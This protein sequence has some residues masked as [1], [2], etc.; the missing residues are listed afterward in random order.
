MEISKFE[1]YL[2]KDVFS[3]AIMDNDG[4]ASLPMFTILEVISKAST[5]EYKKFLKLCKDYQISN[6]PNYSP[7]ELEFLRTI[8]PFAGEL[9]NSIVEIPKEIVI[10]FCFKYSK[11]II[12]RIGD[13]CQKFNIDWV[14]FLDYFFM[15]KDSV[16]LDGET[17]TIPRE[18][19]INARESLD[20][21][22]K[23]V[24]FDEM[25]DY[26][27]L[28][29]ETRENSEVVDRDS[30]VTIFNHPENFEKEDKTETRTESFLQLDKIIKE[31]IIPKVSTKFKMPYDSVDAV[32]IKTLPF[33]VLV[34]YRFNAEE[35]DYIM[36]SLQEQDILVRGYSQDME[37]YE[38]YEYIATH[39]GSRRDEFD[40]VDYDLVTINH[41]HLLR[42]IDK[43][44]E[45]AKNNNEPTD[46]LE[47]QRKAVKREIVMD[48]GRLLDFCLYKNHLY[49]E[50]DRQ[51]GFIVLQS[52][53]DTF[54][55]DRG[56]RFSTYMFKY[57][58]MQVRRLKHHAEDNISF[59][60]G[61]RDELTSFTLAKY[62]Y[63]KKGIT[64]KAEDFALYLSWP[65]E[66]VKRFIAY[67]RANEKI[68]FGSIED[69]EKPDDSFEINSNYS[70]ESMN[71]EDDPSVLRVDLRDYNADLDSLVDNAILKSI[72]DDVL[73][74]LTPREEQIIRLRFG[75]D[76]DEPKTLEETA[77]VFNI[78][79]ERIRQI[80][81]KA[82]RKLRHPSRAK[83]LAGLL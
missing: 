14:P 29:H 36:R 41:F 74:T 40:Y 52:F 76:G 31:Q 49:S 43:R 37:K 21:L 15:I 79:R 48:T 59:S 28:Q 6:I 32:E 69:T 12:D 33:N 20:S 45:E 73:G 75:L 30:F 3:K 39:R 58:P 9:K 13:L 83:K 26:F 56:A 77:K 54:D 65:I 24:A 66:K 2:L 63:E 60:P 71:L 10:S 19:Y 72:L 11:E 38:N 25:C 50:D 64:P 8:Y 17:L 53:I 62:Y 51:H 34:K 27:S 80:E 47:E 81:A 46:Q 7:I 18:A 16:Y 23:I 55:P 70:P 78:T 61:V 4:K 82:L 67:A 5:E 42:K 1:H 35:L 57:L 22:G 68:T 44:L